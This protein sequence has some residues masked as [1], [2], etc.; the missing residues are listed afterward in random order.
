MT[1]C[2]YVGVIEHELMHALGFWHEQSR[3]DRDR[4]VKIVWR[5]IEPGMEK[6]FEKFSR[7]EVQD[8]DQSYDY[9]SLMHYGAY[10]FSK[11]NKPTIVPLRRGADIGQRYAL[12]QTDIT[13]I[14]KLYDCTRLF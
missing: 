3:S 9:K 14:N 10:A 7:K 8:L 12:S 4:F 1:G 6:N 11:D 13:K 2:T 5:N